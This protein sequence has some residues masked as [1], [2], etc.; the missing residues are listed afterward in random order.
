ML[1]MRETRKT[2][3]TAYDW[4]ARP[5]EAHAHRV[6]GGFKT[7]IGTGMAWIVLGI[8]GFGLGMLVAFTIFRIAGDTDRAARRAQRKLDPFADVT[9]T[10]AP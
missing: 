2:F 5:A 6:F 1:R 3:P 8:V 9:I 10:R 4:G 7:T